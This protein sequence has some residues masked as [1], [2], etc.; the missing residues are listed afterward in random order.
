MTVTPVMMG[1]RRMLGR[2]VA[3]YATHHVDPVIDATYS[4]DDAPAA[5]EA[6]AAARHMGKIVITR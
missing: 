1:N 3:A 5:Y 4:F 6:L 2:M